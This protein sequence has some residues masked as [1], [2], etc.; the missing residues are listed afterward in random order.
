MCCDGVCYQSKVQDDENE[1][2]LSQ[3][4]AEESTALFRDL[5]KN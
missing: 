3:S 1:E 4:L 5:A 2:M